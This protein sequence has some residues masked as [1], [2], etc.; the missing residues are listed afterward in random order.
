MQ[1]YNII[2]CELLGLPDNYTTEQLEHVAYTNQLVDA[3]IHSMPLAR[4]LDVMNT[5]QEL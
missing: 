4:R 5:I 1:L 3:W 2:G